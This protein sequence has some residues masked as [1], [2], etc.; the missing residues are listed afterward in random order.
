MKAPLHPVACLALALAAC[1][2]DVPA[3]DRS[4]SAAGEP[5]GA[6]SPQ[7]Q[8]ADT[9]RPVPAPRFTRLVERTVIGLMEH[10][11]EDWFGQ[12]RAIA[13]DRLGRLYVAD[14]YTTD[15]RVFDSPGAY[16]RTL[17]RRGQGPGEFIWPSGLIWQDDSTL[18]VLDN[19]GNHRYSAYDTSGAHIKDR[20]RLPL[21]AE[22]YYWHARFD[23]K[24]LTESWVRAGGRS[25]LVAIDPEAPFGSPEVPLG[26]PQDTFPYPLAG[27]P[28]DEWGPM[29]YVRSGT[30]VRARKVPF[31]EGFEW[32]LDGR[33]AVWVGDTRTGRLVRR[34]LVG[35][36]LLVITHEIAGAPVSDEERRAAIEALGPYASELDRSR[37]PDRKPVFRMIVPSEDGGVLLVREGEGPAWFVDMLD[38]D[39]QMVGS[40]ELPVEPDLKVFPVVRGS[41]FWVVTRG[42]LDVQFVVRFSMQ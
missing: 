2:P 12:I 17:G 15:V 21:G 14:T 36:T 31:T 38:A 1:S 37:I 18:W 10:G 25:R 42:A 33:G 24:M 7:D 8:Q 35:D 40:A 34:S 11:P 16:V 23:G 6:V 39:G 32:I 22:L 5:A 28:L 27:V 9:A 41:D 30:T 13:V 19:S 20:R 3:S 4:S 29:V 26:A